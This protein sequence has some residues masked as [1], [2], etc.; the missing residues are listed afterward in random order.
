MDEAD[1]LGDRI[2]IMG[3]GQIKCCG[4]SLYL[5]HLYDCGYVFTIIMTDGANSNIIKPLIDDI[6]LNKINN[7]KFIEFNGNELTHHLPMNESHKFSELFKELDINK[8]KLNID[9]YGISITTLEQVFLKIDNPDHEVKSFIK[10]RNKRKKSMF[11]QPRFQLHNQSEFWIFVIHVYAILYKIVKWTM[12]D[13][14]AICFRIIWPILSTFFALIVVDAALP[15]L[16]DLPALQLN[17]G[18]YY[19]PASDNIIGISQYNGSSNNNDFYSNPK[20]NETYY[21]KLSFNGK[22]M[23]GN[24]N[25]ISVTDQFQEFLYNNKGNWCNNVISYGSLYMNPET[26]LN[27]IYLGI[28]VSSYHSLPIMMNL[29]NNLILNTFYYNNTTPIFIK[30]TN[31]PMP[32]TKIEKR[33]TKNI[34]DIVEGLLLT[35]SLMIAFTFIPPSAIYFLVNERVMNTKHQQFCSGLNFFAYWIGT[36]IG[37][38]ILSLPTIIVIY[39]GILTL[40]AGESFRGPALLPGLITIALFI[41][42]SLPFAY[43]LSFVFRK[44]AT[45]QITCFVAFSL[46]GAILLLVTYLLEQFDK[47]KDIVPILRDLFRIFPMYAMSDNLLN[48]SKIFFAK[49]FSIAGDNDYWSWDNTLRNYTYMGIEVIMYFAILFIIE[50]LLNFPGLFRRLGLVINEPYEEETLDNDVFNEQQRIK[51]AMVQGYDRK[52]DRINSNKCDDAVVL[53]G[54]RK[55]Y[56]SYPKN[57]VAVKDLW[58]GVKKNMIFGFL[59]VN[60]AG[61]STTLDLLTGNKYPSSGNAYIYGIPITN[62]NIIRR[63]IGYC[64]QNNC[65]FNKL[66]GYE[67]LKFYGL[68]KGLNGILLNKEINVLLNSLLLNKYKNKILNNYSGGNKRK[69][70]VGISMIGNPPIIFLDEP[71]T[72]VDP[73]SKRHMWEFINNTMNNRSVILT[74]HSM[75]ECQALSN[76][77]AIMIN[78]QLSCIGTSQYLKNKFG[79]GYQLTLIIKN[80]SN[81]NNEAVKY[82]QSMYLIIKKI[83]EH[84]SIKYNYEFIEHNNQTLKIKLTQ[85]ESNNDIK[86]DN[87]YETKYDTNNDNNTKLKLSELFDYIE[88]MKNKFPIESYALTQQTLEQVFLRMANPLK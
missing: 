43:I 67:N 39:I 52:L 15:Q 78:G 1:T 64:N 23:Y 86:T 17:T 85:K 33:N 54:L 31:H 35:L 18:I 11:S 45:A 32:I 30:L 87:D 3:G 76:K 22:L 82:T 6:I 47:T 60:G 56:K 61:K 68:L 16:T 72:G 10:T 21:H 38:I 46:L 49:K 24:I 25:P 44:P 27:N 36:F 37:D 29:F 19:E 12:R 20:W 70:C 48:Y 7:S 69:L 58:F 57:N 75:D 34:K 80:T 74:T 2:C 79:K 59:G 83:R 5:K 42:S 77:V 51:K 14:R 65:V 26:S 88:K 9:T 28:N 41:M 81:T 62:Q 53:C 13:Y 4:S 73:L 8:N 66:T 40:K 84:L 55:V 71:S 63:Y 50:I